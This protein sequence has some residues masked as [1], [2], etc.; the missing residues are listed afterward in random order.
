MLR[1]PTKKRL[2]D[3]WIWGAV[4]TA[5]GPYLTIGFLILVL[6]GVWLLR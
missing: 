1:W 4:A 3:Y 2:P 5:A 6:L